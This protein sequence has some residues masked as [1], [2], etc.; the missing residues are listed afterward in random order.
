MTLNHVS[1]KTT[2]PLQILSIENCVLFLVLTAIE[3]ADFEFIVHF[4]AIAAVI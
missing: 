1:E 2:N 3:S 4:L